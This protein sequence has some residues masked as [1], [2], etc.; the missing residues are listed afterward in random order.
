VTTT[1]IYLVTDAESDVKHLVRAAT[2]AQAVAHV[3]QRFTAAVATQ[4]DL[5]GAVADGIQVETYK[6]ARQPDLL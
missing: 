2:T 5:V 3:S 4:D 1:R 6:P